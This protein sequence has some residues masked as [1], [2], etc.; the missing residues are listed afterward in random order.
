MTAATTTTPSQARRIALLAA[1]WAA[2]TLA[3][4]IYSSSLQ[5]GPEFG[6]HTTHGRWDWTADGLTDGPGEN[7][8]FLDVLNGLSEYEVTVSVSLLAGKGWGLFWGAGLERGDRVSGYTFQYDPGYGRGAHLLRHWT[9]SR[10]SVLVAVPADL[11]RGSFHNF[12]FKMWDRGFRAFQ[13]ANLVLAYDGP[14]PPSGDLLG[15]RTWSNSEAVFRDLTVG[16]PPSAAPVPE[17][18]T[19]LLML[20]GVGLLGWQRR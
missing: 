17:S 6:W 7:R 3:T 4:P 1:L 14:L 19:M 15:L 12:R 10:E 11:D 9:E 20:A 18:C 16:R 8:I 13:E 5:S 2:P